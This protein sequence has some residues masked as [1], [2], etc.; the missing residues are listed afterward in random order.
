MSPPL[1]ERAQVPTTCIKHAAIPLC[2]TMNQ[3]TVTSDLNDP[4]D[5]VDGLAASLPP[6]PGLRLLQTKKFVATETLGGVEAAHI[7]TQH[8]A[9]AMSA[10]TIADLQVNSNVTQVDCQAN[11]HND[12]APS[13]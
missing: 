7:G 3:S 9:Q 11:I 8:N 1:S 6:L 2:P 10:D 5:H 13:T 4:N 12:D